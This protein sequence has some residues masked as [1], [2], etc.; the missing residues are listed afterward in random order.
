MFSLFVIEWTRGFIS[1][2]EKQLQKGTK[3]LKLCMEMKLHVTKC[4]ILERDVR[5]GAHIDWYMY[6]QDTYIDW[7]IYNWHTHTLTDT[8][9]DRH[10]HWLIRVLT[11]TYIDRYIYNPHTHTHTLTYTCTNR[12]IHWLIDI[13]L[14]H[15]FTDTWSIPKSTSNWLVKRNMSS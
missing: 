7:Y 4:I 14:K 8:C 12:H 6:W 11:D 15:T 9:T 13:K 5:T 1:H 2:S 3:C 10:I